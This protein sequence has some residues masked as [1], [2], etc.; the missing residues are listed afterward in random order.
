MPQKQFLCFQ[1]LSRSLLFHCNA[2]KRMVYWRHGKLIF[3]KDFY[4]YKDFIF[5]R[6]SFDDNIHPSRAG[7]DPRGMGIGGVVPTNEPKFLSLKR[8]NI[9]NLDKY[10]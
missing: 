4:I 10:K 6:K 3:M 7:W 9:K 8:L 1:Q 5:M 2:S